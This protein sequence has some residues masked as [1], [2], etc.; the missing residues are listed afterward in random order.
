MPPMMYEDVKKT[1]DSCTDEVLTLI[2]ELL[3]REIAPWEGEHDVDSI[4][5]A[6]VSLKLQ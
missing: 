4:V 5:I 1:L 6:P 3:Y 2:L